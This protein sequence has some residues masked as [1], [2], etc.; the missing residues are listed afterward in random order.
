M[1]LTLTHGCFFPPVFEA[2]YCLLVEYSIK[3]GSYGVQK[4]FPLILLSFVMRPHSERHEATES[5]RKQNLILYYTVL[6]LL[7]GVRA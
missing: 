1:S 7:G 2:D 3:Y 5:E 6:T 4:I